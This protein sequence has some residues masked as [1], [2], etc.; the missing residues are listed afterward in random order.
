MRKKTVRVVFLVSSG[1]FV[2]KAFSTIESGR[3]KPSVFYIS[4]LK[5]QISLARLARSISGDESGLGPRPIPRGKGSA[6]TGNVEFSR[7]SFEI[8]LTSCGKM[9]MISLVLYVICNEKEEYAVLSVSESCRPVQGSVGEPRKIT[10][11]HAARTESKAR[12]PTPVT[13]L[14]ASAGAAERSVFRQ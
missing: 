6:E 3:Q 2:K 5:P 12:R 8:M 7:V 1:R 11:E 10:L 13:A 9:G 4:P 14:P